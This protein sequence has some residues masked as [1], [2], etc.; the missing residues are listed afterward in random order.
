MRNA[1]PQGST[2][3]YSSWVG[4]HTSGLPW[5]LL[6]PAKKPCVA[7]L[8]CSPS[9]SFVPFSSLLVASL[10]STGSVTGTYASVEPCGRRRRSLSLS[11]QKL[12]RRSRGTRGIRSAL[13]QTPAAI[14]QRSMADSKRSS[15]SGKV[16]TPKTAG[17][18]PASSV[19]TLA[20]LGKAIGARYAHLTQ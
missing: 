3:V 20:A 12:K 18:P 16:A 6:I 19:D 5:T 2:Q 14:S 15:V 17:A 13:S 4:C 11:L 7:Q 9:V 1:R 8:V 10:K